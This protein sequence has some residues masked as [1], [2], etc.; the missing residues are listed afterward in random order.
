MRE[1]KYDSWY[2]RRVY[3]ESSG[4]LGHTLEPFLFVAVIGA[5]NGQVTVVR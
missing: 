3:L 2:I 5:D 4:S 1:S